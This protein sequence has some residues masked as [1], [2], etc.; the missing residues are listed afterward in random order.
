MAITHYLTFASEAEIVGL[1]GLAMFAVA[2]F[3]LL[4]EKRRN[5][6]ARIDRIGWVPWLNIFLTSAM[7]GA[8]L[9]AL[10]AKGIIAGE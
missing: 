7:I 5:K 6:V 9:I 8:G 1:W 10:A 4:A 3:A 2:I